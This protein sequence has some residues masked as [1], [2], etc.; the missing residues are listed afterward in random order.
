MESI[1]SASYSLTLRVEFP[2]EAGALGKISDDRRG[3]G[4]DGRRGRHRADAPGQDRPRHYRQRP[5][6]RAR[7]AGGPGRRGSAPGQGH[8]RLRQDVPDAPRGQDRGPLQAPD[9]YPRRPLY[10][11]HA[12][13]SPR[14]QGDS[15]RPREGLQPYH[16]AQHGRGRLGRHGRPRARGHRAAGRDAGDGG[17]GGALQAVRQ[18]GRVPDLPRHQGHGRDRRD[19][20]E[21]GAGVRRHKPGGHLGPA[22]LRDRRSAEEGARH[23]RLPRRPARHGRRRAGGPDQLP[24]DRRARRS[25]TSASS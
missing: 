10:G 25:R 20:Q 16:Q 19:R 3:C 1:P 22:V 14:L 15:Q 23:P 6:L 4:R 5:R 21:P 2:H 9:P 24:Q 12:R 13:C 18:R 17:Q 11:L 8:Q 7:P